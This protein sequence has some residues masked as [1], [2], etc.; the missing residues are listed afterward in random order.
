MAY[1]DG[2]DIVSDAD[3]LGLLLLDE[4]GHGVDS[5]PEDGGPLGGGVALACGAGLGALTEALLA[6]LLGLGTVLVQKLE[7]LG[8]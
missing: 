4:G 5:M 8:G 7:Q 2:V 3:E 1:L 6:G